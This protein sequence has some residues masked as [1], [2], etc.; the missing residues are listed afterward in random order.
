MDPV[1]R[2]RRVE[3]GARQI[4]Q[5]ARIAELEKACGVEMRPEVKRE[6]DKIM[7]AAERHYTELKRASHERKARF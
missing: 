2:R 7:E 6:V 3:E 4:L 5:A 1:E